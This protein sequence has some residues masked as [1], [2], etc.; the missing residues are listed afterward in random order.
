MK[1]ADIPC[2]FDLTAKELG[3]IEFGMAPLDEDS[4]VWEHVQHSTAQDIVA[5]LMDRFHL[6]VDRFRMLAM[7]GPE[8]AM[9][10]LKTITVIGLS[11]TEVVPIMSS[12]QSLS[13]IVGGLNHPDAQ[14]VEAIRVLTHPAVK[15]ATVEWNS[16]PM[17]GPE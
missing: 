13:A 1:I 6:A 11:A 14:S 4:G 7:R 16:S 2:F 8:F 3:T 12:R 15:K 5:R 10:D 17:L 9:I